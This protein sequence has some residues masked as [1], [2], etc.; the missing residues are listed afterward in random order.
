ME[1]ARVGEIVS[2]V[3]EA[4]QA[5]GFWVMHSSSLYS[6]KV[7]QSRDASKTAEDRLHKT[8]NIIEDY[9]QENV[10]ERGLWSAGTEGVTLADICLASL[11]EYARD[12][13]GRDLCASGEHEVLKV[14][15]GK[16]EGTEAGKRGGGKT[17]PEEFARLARE[18]VWE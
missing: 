2:L 6:P 11:V 18:N 17:P 12:F 1:R 4:S 15:V 9:C 7:R 14:W 8:L 13:Y 5:F 3:E 10:V 16:W